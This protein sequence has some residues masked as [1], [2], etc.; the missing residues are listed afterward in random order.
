[1]PGGGGGGAV[2]PAGRG[3]GSLCRGKG[4]FRL[5]GQVFYPAA[6]MTN[7]QCREVPDGKQINGE[8]LI[9]LDMEYNKT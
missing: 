9:S 6:N 3:G 1:M 7:E 2:V 8:V 5:V 4:L